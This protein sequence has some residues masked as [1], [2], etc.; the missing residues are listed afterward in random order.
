MDNKHINRLVLGDVIIA[1]CNIVCGIINAVT[2]GRVVL[3]VLN[4]VIAVILICVAFVTAT[5]KPKEPPATDG[6]SQRD[7][8]LDE[9]VVPINS[10]VIIRYDTNKI[11]VNDVRAVFGDAC[12]AFPDNVVIAIPVNVQIESATLDELNDIQNVVTQAIDYA[13]SKKAKPVDLSKEVVVDEAV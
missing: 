2:G 3:I 10:T 8:D 4:F 12:K 5:Y 7:Y 1:I 6:D 9:I 11:S 13:K